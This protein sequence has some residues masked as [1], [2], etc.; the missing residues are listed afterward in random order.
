V[1]TSKLME[2]SAIAE[3]ADRVP[4]ARDF[5]TDDLQDLDAIRLVGSRCNDCGIA[6]LRRRHRCENCAS[7][8]VVHRVFAPTGS[9][10]SFTIQRYPPPLP[11][12]AQSPW[13]PRPVAWVDIDDDG[14]RIISVVEAAPE[15]MAIGMPVRLVCT[16]NAHSD[17]GQQVVTYAFA[18]DGRA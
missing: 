17:N 18:P 7:V 14:P 2:G 9:I 13:I 15:D 1:A 5:L 6:L 11:F 16:V 3:A 8:K 4:F 12:V 10:Y